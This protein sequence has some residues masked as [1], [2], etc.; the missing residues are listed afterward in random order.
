MRPSTSTFVVTNR[1]GVSAI[2]GRRSKCCG[3]ATDGTEDLRVGAAAAEVPA[4]RRDHVGIARIGIP[5]EERCGG[6]QLAG[7]AEA[8]LRGILGHEG[9]LERMR[10][11]ARPESF[12]RAHGLP[13]APMHEGQAAVDGLAIE[14]DG[15]GPAFAAVADALGSGEIECVAQEIEEGGFS[16]RIGFDAPAVDLEVHARDLSGGAR[17]VQPA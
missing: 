8:T 3:G 6:H 14:Q 12:D 10:R 1:R 5:R 13:N 4:Q 2:D 9:G 11:G 16:R 17:T 7:R 15:A